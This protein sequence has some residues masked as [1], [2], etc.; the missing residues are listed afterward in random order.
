[1]I[2]METNWIV[3]DKDNKGETN[4]ECPT[5]A[6][7]MN[8]IN[9]EI[10]DDDFTSIMPVGRQSIK[11]KNKQREKEKISKSKAQDPRKC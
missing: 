5:E 4:R 11:L 7:S 6:H 1:M 10:D 9:E 8:E 3:T 2:L